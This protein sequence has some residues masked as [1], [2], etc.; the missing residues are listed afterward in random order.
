VLVG[1]SSQDI[2]STATF[3]LT[4]TAR[5][6]GPSSQERAKLNLSST[7]GQLLANEGARAI[8]N[9]HLP[10]MLDT[11]QVEMAKNLTLEQIASFVPDILTDEVI[12]RI[13]RDLEQ[14]GYK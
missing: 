12:Q 14:I 7:L 11:P 5:F 10:G 1:S 8:L 6:G 4:A 13:G 3:T 9:H 2:R